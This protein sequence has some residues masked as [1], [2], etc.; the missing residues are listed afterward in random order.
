MNFLAIVQDLREQCGVSASA[1]NAQPTTVLNQTGEMLRLVNW[2]KRAWLSI[3]NSRDWWLWMSSD[4]TLNVAANV[5]E[6]L[7]TAGI[8]DRT[9]LAINRFARWHRR[10]LRLYRQGVGTTDEQF[11][12]DWDFEKFRDAYLFAGQRDQR[13]RPVVWAER[14][15]TRGILLG[16]VPDQAYTIRGRYQRGPQNLA[17]DADIPELPDRFHPLIVYRA[18]MYYGKYEAAPEVLAQGQEEFDRMMSDLEREQLPPMEI[19]HPLA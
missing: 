12:V 13:N 6:Y 3:Q 10:S 18:M 19:Q 17:I 1:E 2:T 11:L 15:E 4:F 14:P 9:G 7:P 5:G 8:D 16:D